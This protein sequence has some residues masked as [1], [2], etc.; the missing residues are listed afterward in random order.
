MPVTIDSST[1]TDHYQ[2]TIEK[3]GANKG[4]IQFKS[5]PQGADPTNTPPHKSETFKLRHIKAAANGSRILCQA[6]IW[7]IYPTVKCSVNGPA[8]AASVEVA[9]LGNDDKYPVDAA[10]YDEITAF[11]VASQCPVLH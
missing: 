10:D 2:I 7:P 6:D 9:F 8:T 4:T 11:I 5:W 1:A 3:T